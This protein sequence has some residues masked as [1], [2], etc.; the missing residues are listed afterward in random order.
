MVKASQFGG[1]SAATSAQKTK[2]ILFLFEG[3]DH[4]VVDHLYADQRADV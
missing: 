2:G 3:A 1:V 4:L